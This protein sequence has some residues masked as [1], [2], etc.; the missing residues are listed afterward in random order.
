MAEGVGTEQ[1]NG[2][3]FSDFCQLCIR[4]QGRQS[5]AGAGGVDQVLQVSDKGRVFLIFT[6]S[7]RSRRG[8]ASRS[9]KG[10]SGRWNRG[11]T[12]YGGR[13]RRGRRWKRGGRRHKI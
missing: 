3:L 5:T 1:V 4:A 11:L 10:R 6:G 9:R 13:N 7:G 12:R 2:V 8:I